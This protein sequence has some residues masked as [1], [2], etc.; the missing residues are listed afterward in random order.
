MINPEL[1]KLLGTMD[2]IQE[3]LQNFDQKS[4]D[5]VI[6]DLINNHDH[7]TYQNKI[8]AI[9]INSFQNKNLSSESIHLILLHFARTESD[10]FSLNTKTTV[11]EIIDHP[12]IQKNDFIQVLSHFYSRG[13]CLRNNFIKSENIK[14][15]NK[16]CEQLFLTLTPGLI[17]F[18]RESNYTFDLF[19][20]ALLH[21]LLNSNKEVIVN[22]EFTNA[23]FQLIDKLSPSLIHRRYCT[24]LVPTN[25]FYHEV[26]QN[27]K[28]YYLEKFNK[29][30]FDEIHKITTNPYSR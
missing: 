15:Y 7:S 9:L 14:K 8:N 12:N 16:D 25:E 18:F 20:S 10:F 28:N 13:I 29:L 21:F 5:A 11:L 30:S 3:D 26:F 6:N 2:E 24:E 1:T 27:A 19:L 17:G 22:P 23:L 4:L